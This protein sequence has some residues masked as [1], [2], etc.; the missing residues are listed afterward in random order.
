LQFPA[1]TRGLFYIDLTFQTEEANDGGYY[2]RLT[3]LPDKV[4]FKVTV[5][6][7]K[8]DPVIA[9][10]EFYLRKPVLETFV[11]KLPGKMSEWGKKYQGD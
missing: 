8:A 2:D 11:V 10:D 3:D 7:D 5:E 4:D 6:A 9:E 1:K